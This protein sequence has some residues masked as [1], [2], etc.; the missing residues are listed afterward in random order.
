MSMLPSPSGDPDL[1][2]P[3]TLANPYPLYH[4]LRALAPVYWAAGL[5]GWLV[6]GYDAVNAVARNAR[7]SVQ[8]KSD[9]TRQR[10][11]DFRTQLLLLPLSRNM[12]STD[13]PAHTRLRALVGKAF[14]PAAVEGMRPR[15][16]QLVDRYLDRAEARGTMDVIADLAGPLPVQI[17]LA[18][19]GIPAEDA[20][21]FRQWSDAVSVL[22]DWVGT[23]TPDQV[24]ALG[25]AITE[26]N[27]YLKPLIEQRRAWPQDDLL[28]AMIL[29]E[30]AG[31]RLSEPEVYSNTLLLLGTGHETTTHL[32]GNGTLA[33]LRHPD[34]YRKLCEQ[35][36]LVPQATEELLRYDCSVQISVRKA[37]EDF[38]AGGSTVR[39]GQRLF[40]I[41]GAANRDPAR[42]PDPDRLDVTRP[43]IKHLAFGAGTHY[44]LGAALARLECQIAFA[45]LIRRF[46]RM[47]LATDQLAYRNNHN[48]RGLK[49]LTVTW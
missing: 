49:S 27:A 26:F 11:K 34:Q 21:R 2:G 18:M 23:V 10:I 42:F 7:V 31:E 32:I 40:L 47:R 13:P 28:S 4:Q 25:K 35:P 46:P 20:E 12:L 48:L 33:L 43:D 38:D 6:T 30:D 19:L 44:C 24:G 16:Q 17:I 22:N 9:L 3:H 41:W 29:A 5:D 14:S 37:T 39:Q 1:F 45:E 36:A 15:I 8:G